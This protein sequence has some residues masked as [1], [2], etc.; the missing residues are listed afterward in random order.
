GHV[1]VGPGGTAGIGLPGRLG[2]IRGTARAGALA[3]GNVAPDGLGPAARARRRGQR[4]A[5]DRGDVLGGGGGRDTD[6][7]VAGRGGGGHAWVLKEVGV[8]AGIGGRRR[9]AVAVG[10]EASAHADRGVHR[11]AQVGQVRVTGLDQEDVA[12]RA[13]GRDHVEVQRLLG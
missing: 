3:A 10:Y 6:P 4:G 9:G 2:V 12:G 5:A 8:V 1:V 13:D 11:R 7:A